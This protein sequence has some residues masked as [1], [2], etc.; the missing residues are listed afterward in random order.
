M[1]NVI[2]T[3]NIIY[4]CR[5]K[6]IKWLIYTSSASVVFDG[7]D[8]EGSNE[9]MPY[10]SHPL[11]NYTATKALAEQCVLK[12]DSSSLKTLA[13]RPH[14]VLGPGDNHLIPGI[15]K[16]AK[17]G[18]LRQIGDGK[19][20]IGLSYIDNVIAAH[21]CAAQAIK[22]NP[23][24]SGKAYFISNGDPVLLWDFINMIL[25]KGELEPIN[26]SVPVRTAFLFSVLTEL[27]YKI[28]MIKKRASVN[29]VF[30]A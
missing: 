23:E 16:K 22:N 8:I 2:G 10:P 28:F 14:I 13:L 12:A 7:T 18:K 5:E 30:S 1:T 20:I 11:S 15:F 4:A 24:V 19:N 29:P 26:K 6:K 17:A 25:K 21:I 9:S 3:E 27:F